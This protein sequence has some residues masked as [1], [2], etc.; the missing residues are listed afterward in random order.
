MCAR[1]WIEPGVQFL[2]TLRTLLPGE[3]R[4]IL[5]LLRLFGVR[6]SSPPL[7]PLPPFPQLSCRLVCS[8][9]WN[10]SPPPPPPPLLPPLHPDES[11]SLSLSLCFL[12]KALFHCQGCLQSDYRILYQ[13][14]VTSVSLLSSPLRS[15]EAFG[16]SWSRQRRNYGFARAEA[17]ITCPG[18]KVW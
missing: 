4:W 7:S 6:L 13:L 12:L 10:P 9:S 2:R 1:A 16:C 3:L 14:I 11:I 18:T 8:Y 5:P 17:A 15:N